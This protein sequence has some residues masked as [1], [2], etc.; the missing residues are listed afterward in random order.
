MVGSEKV[1]ID[2]L[3]NAD[4]SYL[5]SAILRIFRELCDGIHRIVSANVEEISYIVL[6]EDLDDLFKCLL[7][8]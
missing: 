7:I 1:V 6:F 8:F 4:D 2:G 5:V 3:G